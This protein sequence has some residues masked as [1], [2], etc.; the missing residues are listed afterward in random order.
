MGER[1]TGLRVLSSM[2][3]GR[4][5][6]FLCQCI[7]DRILSWTY[8]NKQITTGE[9]GVVVTD[10]AEIAR[11]CWRWPIRVRGQLAE[12]ISAVSP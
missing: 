7:D 2:L 3:T 12:Y 1:T 11:P 6:T 4:L 5:A 8:P 9:G 10:S